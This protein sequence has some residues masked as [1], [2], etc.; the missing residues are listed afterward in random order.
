MTFTFTFM[1]LWKVVSACL[2]ELSLVKSDSEE[3]KRRRAGRVLTG[4]HLVTSI[5]VLLSEVESFTLKCNSKSLQL[6]TESLG[7]RD[8][9]ANQLFT[10]T[11]ITATKIK[12]PFL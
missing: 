2:L 4:D 11:T 12:H 6:V 5:Q 7:R 8:K 9:K 1:E 10:K 3:V